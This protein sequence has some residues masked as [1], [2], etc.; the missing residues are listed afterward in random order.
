MRL[1]ALIFLLINLG[2]LSA[3]ADT[4][5]VTGVLLETNGSRAGGYTVKIYVIKPNI[6]V[7]S[8][9]TSSNGI[10]T[11]VKEN[12]EA[13]TV[14]SW[15]VICEQGS[16]KVVAKLVFNHKPS[17]IWQA[18]VEDLMLR[19]SNQARY[20]PNEAAE[21]IRTITAIQSIKAKSGE[22]T[23]ETANERAEREVA[24]VLGR[25]DLGQFP[26]T[27]LRQINQAVVQNSDPNLSQLTL[28]SADKFVH[29]RNRPEF[30]NLGP[31]I[32]Q[33]FMQE[34]GFSGYTWSHTIDDFSQEEIIDIIKFVNGYLQLIAGKRPFGFT[35]VSNKVPDSSLVSLV[36]TD[37]LK[38]EDIFDWLSKSPTALVWASNNARLQRHDFTDSTKTEI[39]KILEQFRTH[40]FDLSALPSVHK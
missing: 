3:R 6:G 8:D 24:H 9:D 30:K 20:S 19:S 22:Q 34:R 11:I 29:L 10:Y 2:D 37:K 39:L 38:S 18:K 1:I 7:S 21:T 12:V 25:T 31:D 15:Y 26:D 32:R 36:V 14:D 27:T 28:M 33:D 35:V 5:V 17:N 16:R 23:L 4:L 13:S 40:N